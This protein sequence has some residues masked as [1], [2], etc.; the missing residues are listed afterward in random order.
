MPAGTRI[1]ESW[2]FVGF[3]VSVM[4]GWATASELGL[5]NVNCMGKACGVGSPT[6]SGASFKAWDLTVSFS[7]ESVCVAPMFVTSKELL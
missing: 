3:T 6:T 2:V 4:L 7:V 1:A 5:V